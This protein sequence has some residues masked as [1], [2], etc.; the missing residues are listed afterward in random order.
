MMKKFAPIAYLVPILFLAAILGFQLLPAADSMAGEKEV[1]A[2]SDAESCG[3]ECKAWHEKKL[4]KM[5]A[6]DERLNSLVAKMD[7]A[8]GDD[9]V[10]AMAAVINELVTQR[11]EMRKRHAHG[12]KYKGCGK[13]GERK[14]CASSKCADKK[15]DGE[16]ENE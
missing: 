5:A 2:C 1:K 6:M 8:K 14:E 3:K 10:E 16:A 4:A 12:K 7:E 15:K 11:T 13:E 9:K